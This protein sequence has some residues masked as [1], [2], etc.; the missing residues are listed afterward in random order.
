MA[1]QQYEWGEMVWLAGAEVGNATAV[2]VARMRVHP[3]GISERHCHPNC[4]EV[5]LVERG[6]ADIEVD[7]V[8][9][10]C[11][12]GD[13]VVVPEGAAHHVANVG[14]Q[15]LSLILSYGT[16]LRVYQPC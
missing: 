11:E 13:V 15:E 16:G 6:Q 3:G 12:P 4:E 2:S 5:I 8:H 14:T 7:F 1:M 9:S 10:R